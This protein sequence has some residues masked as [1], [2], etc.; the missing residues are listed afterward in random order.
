MC[1]EHFN[2]ELI[3][4]VCMKYENVADTKFSHWATI[5][6]YNW[7]WKEIQ[8]LRVCDRTALIY[9]LLIVRLS[10]KQYGNALAAGCF[11]TVI[12]ESAGKSGDEQLH[13]SRL[14]SH[15]QG[16]NQTGIETS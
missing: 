10:N 2:E 5:H 14:P 4:K 15:N 6:L 1:G 8:D 11:T 12:T 3:L 16:G 7:A 9:P 13:S